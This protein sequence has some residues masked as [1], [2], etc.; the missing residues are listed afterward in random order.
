MGKPAEPPA[1]TSY[2]LIVGES[3]MVRTVYGEGYSGIREI[4]SSNAC[5]IDVGHHYPN[6]Y[7]G[8]LQ[9]GGLKIATVGHY[10]LSNGNAIDARIRAIFV[11]ILACRRSDYQSS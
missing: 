4:D 3:D 6:W 1:A 2:N 8:N 7:V 5:F 10:E 11:V 9:V